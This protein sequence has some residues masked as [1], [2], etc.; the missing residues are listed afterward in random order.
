ML[1]EHRADGRIARLR[2]PHPVDAGNKRRA[3]D[4][5]ADEFA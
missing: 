1:P 4:G 2:M 5:K 3:A